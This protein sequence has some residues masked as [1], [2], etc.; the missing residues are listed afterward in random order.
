MQNHTVSFLINFL[1]TLKQ[2]AISI[3]PLRYKE[4]HE[5]LAF[6]GD[7]DFIIS[8]NSIDSVLK[9]LFK[10]A[11]ASNINFVINR[12]KFGKVKIFIYDPQDARSIDLELW[13]HLEV[14][15]DST[16]AYIFYEDIEPYIS[17]Q[18]DKSYALSL[19]I[20]ALYYLS[21]L[22]SKN[23][24]LSMDEIQLRLKYYKNA[25]ETEYPQLHQWYETVINDTSTLKK[26]A[27]QANNILVNKKILYTKEDREKSKQE[28]STRLKIS[29]QRIY[30]QWMR[31]LKITPVVGPDGVGKTSIIEAIKKQSRSKIKYY[32]FKNLFRHNFI[33]Q[34]SRYF[35]QKKLPKDTQKN[36]YDDIYGA[37]IIRIASL[38]FPFLA[39]R[40][41]LSKKFFFSD[42]FFHDFIIKDT[43]FLEKKAV[44]REDWK[45][46]LQRTPNSFWFLHLDAPTDIILER[47]QELNKEAIDSYRHDIFTMYL[48]KPPLIYSYINTSLTLDN[49]TQVL[50]QTA[51]DI[52]IKAK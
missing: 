48:Q 18:K 6:S 21:H 46:L 38:Y 5:D 3:V 37:L 28:R 27:T 12:A 17:M 44:L 23:K 33:Y 39:L 29:R 36:Q 25:L 47:K 30:S 10:L 45:A 31:A 34:I 24:D 4:L 14:K 1:E 49:C 41:L 16:L 9:T 13:T 22:K 43:R 42:R 52:R 11:S 2:E 15:D 26:Y 32:R 20:E 51:K 7:Y 8:K 35:L 40:S 50:M 19:D